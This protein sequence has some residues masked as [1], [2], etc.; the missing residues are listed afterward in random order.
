MK[1]AI[2]TIKGITPLLMH[3]FPLTPVEA[4]EKKT[5]AEQAELIAYRDPD[6]KELYVPGTGIQRGLINAAK[7]SKGKGRGSL[8]SE[9]SA[10]V[11]V[12]TE[13]ASL[14]IKDYTIDTRPVVISATK[15]RILR[16]RPRIEKWEFTFECEFDDSLLSDAQFRKIV[17]DL[18]QRV[19]FL[20]FRPEKKGPF[21][22]GMVT[23]WEIV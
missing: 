14:G 17:D 23:K 9:V 6:T 3:A 18:C 15:G 1:K 10:G 19:G 8:V 11:L 5:P 20:D 12:L 2:V 4:F 22:R 7:F 16:H 13:R 21:G